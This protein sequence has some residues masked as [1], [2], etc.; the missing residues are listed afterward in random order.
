MSIT[1]L[2]APAEAQSRAPA[3]RA[4]GSP[5]ATARALGLG[6]AAAARVAEGGPSRAMRPRR[7]PGWEAGRGGP[8]P[9]RGRCRLGKWGS[10]GPGGGA[11]RA[12][13]G[14]REGVRTPGRKAQCSA[15]GVVRAARSEAAGAL[16]C[17]GDIDKTGERVSPA[18]T[19]TH[20]LE[21]QGQQTLPCPH[22]RKTQLPSPLRRKAG[23]G[24]KRKGEER[25]EGGEGL[26]GLREGRST[27]AERKRGRI[28]G[29]KQRPV[30]PAARTHARSR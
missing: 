28:P 11:G 19:L 15:S 22:W 20:I 29:R 25:E 12:A 4:S 3:P 13:R 16:W 17:R 18:F 14:A 2:Q 27:V 6:P 23:Q 9:R 26:R 5:A 7:K 10:A 1:F 30:S 21:A 24:K 8:P